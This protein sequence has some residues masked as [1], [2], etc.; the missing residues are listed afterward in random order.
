MI[1]GVD[2]TASV[3]MSAREMLASRRGEHKAKQMGSARIARGARSE[4]RGT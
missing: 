3:T 1:A 2:K 4:A